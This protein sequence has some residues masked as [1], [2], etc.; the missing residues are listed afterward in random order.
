M[1]EILKLLEKDAARAWEIKKNFQAPFATMEDFFRCID[2]IF[3]DQ[4]AV[5]YNEDGSITMQFAN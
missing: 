4:E 2:G 1:N 3:M 5:R